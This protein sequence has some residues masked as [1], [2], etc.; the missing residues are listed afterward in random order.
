MNFFS[1]SFLS[2][3]V[4]AISMKEMVN[5][6]DE[7]V[8][9]NKQIW[10]VDI[11]ASKAVAMQNDK[12]L[13]NCLKSCDI[14]GA[15]GKSIVWASRFLGN[16]LPERIAGIDIME[17]LVSLAHQKGYK[18]FFF[19][20]KEDAVRKLTDVYSQK[21]SPDVVAGYRNG[22]YHTDDEEEIVKQIVYSQANILFVATSSPKQELFL[23]NHRNSLTSVNFMMGVGGSFD[24]IAGLRKRAPVWMQKMGMEWVVR[25]I[26]EPR[27][28][29]K[30]YLIGNFLFLKIV[31]MEKFFRHANI[32]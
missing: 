30:R 31:L 2:I 18:C 8:R 17:N 29:W 13:F 5:L 22:Y 15:D 20:A 23:Y 27:R 24:V 14:V 10:Y 6:A 32:Y 16:P 4:A 9:E 11:N 28:M 1:T 19:G 3:P 25:L 21:Y 26:Q 12:N 7:S